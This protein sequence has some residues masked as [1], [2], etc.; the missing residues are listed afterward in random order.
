[1]APK[2]D[3]ATEDA[4]EHSRALGTRV[5]GLER[6]L[7][8]HGS[9]L[10][11][12][13]K[14]TSEKLTA[15]LARLDALGVTNPTSGSDSTSPTPAPPS[16]SDGAST[17]GRVATS[18]YVYDSAAAA[19]RGA[20]RP[21][22]ASVSNSISFVDDT[23]SS[24]RDT[25][26]G[27]KVKFTVKPEE[28]SRFDGRTEETEIWLA[29]LEAMLDSE[30]DP[31]L[32]P[33]WEAAIVRVLPRTLRGAARLWYMALDARARR[34]MTRLHGVGGWFDQ[35]RANF[36]EPPTIIRQQAR[37]RAWNPDQETVLHYS[38]AKVAL[39]KTAWK[40]L[41]DDDTIT[42]I[43][44]GLPLDMRVLLR[45]PLMREQSLGELRAEL[46]VQESYWRERH[47]RPLQ[48]ATENGP[49]SSSGIPN[50]G[51]LL[52]PTQDLPSSSNATAFPQ[53]PASG[54]RPSS[55]GADRSS[56][57]S[58]SR[59]GKSIREDFDPARLFYGPH[60]DTGKRTMAYKVPD[61]KETMWCN[62]ACRTCRGDHFDFAHDYCS[63]NAVHTAD[64]EDD[65]PV[66]VDDVEPG[67]GQ[68]F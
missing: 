36:E 30:I 43:V 57:F 29:D 23:S 33:Q 55:A 5:D 66:T 10:A 19:A 24:D 31:T 4:L 50:F 16:G 27:Y 3:P 28:L 68:G 41:R 48:A 58:R 61:T 25:P 44:D 14:E 7:S 11:E 38:F 52:Q 40:S 46:R 67:S 45:V 21:R 39:L 2:K 37:Q 15:V 60:P 22:S 32:R 65:Y 49:S 17:S 51:S 47:G 62:R 42:D 26:S 34:G 13:R 56:S 59:R 35:I 53:Q 6:T 64:V 9:S 8:E 20:P 63:T 54:P 1:M 12:L 18:S